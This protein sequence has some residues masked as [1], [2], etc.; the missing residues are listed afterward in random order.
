MSTASKQKANRLA[1]AYLVT[2]PGYAGSWTITAFSSGA[3]RYEVLLKMRD[4]GWDGIGFKHLRVR[5]LGSPR[6]TNEFIQMCRARGLVGVSLGDR[7]SLESGATGVI[8]GVATGS[9]L[10]VL[11]DDDSPK[12]AKLR[13][14][15]HPGEPGLV[16]CSRSTGKQVFP[17]G[18][19]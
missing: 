15:V 9:N 10:E 6:N 11:C 12:Y 18:E 8:S 16:I 5:S 1:R 17:R 7:V 14:N 4:A 2:I 13:I 19:S 3:A